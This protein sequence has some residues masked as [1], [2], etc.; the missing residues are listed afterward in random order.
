MVLFAQRRLLADTLAEP[1]TG[2]ARLG[3]YEFIGAHGPAQTGQ[4]LENRLGHAEAAQ[5]RLIVQARLYPAARNRL[6][7]QFLEQFA[8]RDGA[9]FRFGYALHQVGFG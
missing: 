2:A 7:G 6:A 4:G 9:A 3:T 5:G 1:A 8:G